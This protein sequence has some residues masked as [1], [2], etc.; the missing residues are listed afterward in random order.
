MGEHIDE[1][2]NL[3]E[4]VSEE[5]ARQEPDTFMDWMRTNYTDEELQNIAQ[6]GAS[7]GFTGMTYFSETTELHDRY[8]NELWNMLADDTVSYG[9]HN[10]AQFI[11]EMADVSSMGELKNW[12]VWYAAESYARTL[13]G[14]EADEPEEAEEV[15]EPDSVDDE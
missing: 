15:D 3:F 13:T 4:S 11:G 1:F 2:D 10:V 7:A 5:D 6:H 8:E 14:E 9:H 12:I